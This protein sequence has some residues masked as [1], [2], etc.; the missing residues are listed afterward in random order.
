MNT[1]ERERMITEGQKKGVLPKSPFELI[2]KY[3]LA[4]CKNELHRC[5]VCREEGQPEIEFHGQKTICFHK[6]CFNGLC[7]SWSP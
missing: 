6:V 5:A 4:E 2:R 3:M 1:G 7:K